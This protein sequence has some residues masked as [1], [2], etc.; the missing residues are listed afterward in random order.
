MFKRKLPSGKVQYGEWYKDPMTCQLKRITIAIQPTGRKS[1]D[2]VAVEALNRKLTSLLAKSGKPEALT[3]QE[4]TLRR[5]AWQYQHNKI[6]TARSSEMYMRTIVRLIGP[7][8]LVTALNASMVSNM[9]TCP[10]PVTY[11]ERLKH[12]KALLRWAYRN[13]LVEDISYLDKL[14]PDKEPPVREKDKFKYL[15]H[16]EISKLLEAM[17][18]PRWRLLTQFLILSGLRV[19]EAIALNNSDVN[20]KERNIIVDKTLARPTRLI[21]S[22][23]TET[24]NRSIYMQHE[25]Y[26]CCRDIKNYIRKDQQN[27]GYISKIFIP[28]IDGD[29]LSY[30]S[31]AK[32]V[33]ETTE[34]ALGRR[35]T[36]HSFRHTHTA[37][38]AEV[39]VP[40]ETISRRLGHADSEITRQV[41]MHVTEKM[42]NEENAQ[43]ENIKII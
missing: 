16:D 32:Y 10:N 3:F 39:G 9:L 22:T 41:Y 28:Q 13:D 15:E 26:L 27:F 11:N 2:K 19:G 40:L 1:D 29:Y 42:K 17:T 35:L 12:F 5:V 25:L 23:K 43:L 24:S 18:V 37:M 14:Q 31:Y 7:E 6:Q 33:R 20:L 21:S 38:L 30:D 36:P 34:R 4:L 8:T